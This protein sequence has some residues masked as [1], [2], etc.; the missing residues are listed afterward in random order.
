MRRYICIILVCLLL[1]HEGCKREIEG[2]DVSN[3]KRD[4]EAFFETDGDFGD[5]YRQLVAQHP[6]VPLLTVEIDSLSPQ[7]R[8]TVAKAFEKIQK[9]TDSAQFKRREKSIWDQLND[10]QRKLLIK[11]RR[12]RK[13]ILPIMP[14]NYEFTILPMDPL[15]LDWNEVLVYSKALR[16]IEAELLGKEYRLMTNRPFK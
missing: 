3:L 12:K 6:L 16:R 11:L 2:V 13:S 9:N 15:F 4:I 5:H 8:N 14:K 10:K 7:D 1:F